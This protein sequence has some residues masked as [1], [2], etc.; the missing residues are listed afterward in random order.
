LI[1]TGKTWIDHGVDD[2]RL[3]AIKFPFPQFVA[4]FT[5]AMIQ[6]LDSLGRGAP[7]IVGEW[8]HG[9]VGD[10]KSLRF[11]N[12]YA[13]YADCDPRH[14]K[15]CEVPPE[16]VNPGY[17]DP[18]MRVGMTQW[19][20]ETPAFKIIA[21]LAQLRRESPAI[22]QGDYRTL[23]TDPDVLVFERRYQ[24]EVVIAAVNRGNDQTIALPTRV[25]L[26]PGSYP[27]L[28][29]QT[30]TANQGNSLLVS[31]EGQATVSLGPLSA[32]VVWSRPPPP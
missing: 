10:P 9:G 30:S 26:P 1:N 28:L 4:Q 32:L 3:D 20:E 19:D 2:F 16:D 5:H 18:Y 8:S 12:Q 29:S 15:N 23:Y 31:P 25:D 17:D 27:G 11:A 22:A 21:T 6:Y 13:R 14:P 24:H 7:Y